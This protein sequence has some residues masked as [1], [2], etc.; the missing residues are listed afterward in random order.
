[1]ASKQSQYIGLT[2][3]TFRAL[4]QKHN[5]GHCR[6]KGVSHSAGSR[7]YIGEPTSSETIY[8][9]A[10]NFGDDGNTLV[11]AWLREQ[12]GLFHETWDVNIKVS[13]RSKSKES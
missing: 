12:S 9:A 10:A 1:M 7:L 6:L 4:L 13:K 3:W 8:K 5:L 11:E 2:K